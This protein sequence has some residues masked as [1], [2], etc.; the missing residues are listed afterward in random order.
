MDANEPI[1]KRIVIN[2]DSAGA[3]PSG[4]PQ[5]YQVPQKKRR[6]P[7]ILA[8]LLVLMFVVGVAGVVGGYLWWRHYQST[9]AYSIALLVDAAQKNDMPSF[10]KQIDDEAIVRNMAGDVSQK[11][12]SRYG[13][14]LS[15]TL[16]KQI[17]TAVPTLLP[18]LKDTI[19]QEVAKEIKEFASKTEPRPFI[20]VAVAVPTLVTISEQGNRA[21]AIAS[22]P[23][24]KIELGLERS[25]DLWKVTAVKDDVL[26]Q[27][28]VDRVMKDLPAIGAVDVSNQLLKSLSLQKPRKK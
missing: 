9:P 3:I 19:H 27:R 7:K 28:I 15:S 24:R 16:Q 12:A 26:L 10:Q 8:I 25:G 21:T 13:I 5:A 22:L 17:D 6:W 18:R 1:R 2:L 14:A 23:N 20:L 4:R 11:A